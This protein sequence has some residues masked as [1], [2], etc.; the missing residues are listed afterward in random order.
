MAELISKPNQNAETP[1]AFGVLWDLDGVLADTRD[2][3]LHTW[4][5]TFKGLDIPLDTSDF[6]RL[7]GKST[8]Q[9]ILDMMGKD[10]SPEQVKKIGDQKE[11]I[12]R[13]LV[14]EWV[15]LF[16]GVV[17]IL[18]GFQRLGVK[19]A[20]ASSAPV[21]NIETLVNALGIGEYFQAYVSGHNL[22]SKPAPDVFIK[23]ASE[24]GLLP[25]QCVVFEDAIAGVEAARRAGA[26]CIAVTTTNPPSAL[27][28]ADLIL[29]GLDAIPFKALLVKIESWFE[30]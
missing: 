9:I 23:A 14:P 2:L 28:R 15:K 20:I 13:K 26:H 30:K 1:P 17:D 27:E 16:P 3:H 8:P 18:L 7:F 25:S 5:V 19:Q 29:S 12:F 11:E 21:E 24:L 4:E 10:V 22:P 6:Q